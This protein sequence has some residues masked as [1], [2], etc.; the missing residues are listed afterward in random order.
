MNA[1]LLDSLVAIL[2]VSCE[3]IMV[4]YWIVLYWIRVED[5]IVVFSV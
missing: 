5:N 1:C 4:C 2:D 3:K